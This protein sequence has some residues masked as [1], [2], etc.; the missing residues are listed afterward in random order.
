MSHVLQALFLVPP[1]GAN[2]YHYGDATDIRALEAEY[3]ALVTVTKPK[4]SR[5]RSVLDVEPY[6]W[7]CLT[8]A[9]RALCRI[10]GP[11]A[12]NCRTPTDDPST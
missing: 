8:R 4:G 10:N 6:F 12:P 9:G 3:P 7:A 2:V 1:G 11:K 5:S